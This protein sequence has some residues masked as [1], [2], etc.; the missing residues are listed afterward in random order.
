MNKKLL[1][2]GL[3]LASIFL[4]SNQAEAI[5]VHDISNFLDQEV[6]EAREALQK[7][8]RRAQRYNRESE[9][10]AIQRNVVRP[11]FSDVIERNDPTHVRSLIENEKKLDYAIKQRQARDFRRKFVRDQEA[12]NQ[13]NQSI[14]H[15]ESLYNAGV[16][17]VSTEVNRSGELQHIPDY[18]FRRHRNT[19]STIRKNSKQT[20][21]KRLTDY[22]VDGGDAGTDALRSDV[23]KSSEH[24]VDRFYGPVNKTASAQA[25]TV[26]GIRAQQKSQFA[27]LDKVPTGYQK[28]TYKRGASFNKSYTNPYQF[29]YL[30]E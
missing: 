26:A 16:S 9:E 28:T 3:F 17:T 8:G 24:T 11:T 23:I 7:T 18:A 13:I 2:T 12:K 27:S 4:F 30:P 1:G 22:Y 10:L 25:D 14:Q 6:T 20:F 29:Q 21:R 19:P 15:K 5:S